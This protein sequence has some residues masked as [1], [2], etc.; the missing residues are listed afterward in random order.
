MVPTRGVARSGKAGIVRRRMTSSL[1]PTTWVSPPEWL[2]FGY[3]AIFRG[4]RG[5]SLEPVVLGARV[6]LIDEP[7][8]CS[9]FRRLP[10]NRGHRLRPSRQ[11]DNT[12]RIGMKPRWRK[13]S[14]E[15]A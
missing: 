13:G 4:G 5:P 10:R 7:V 1:Q 3:A 2:K 15:G 11:L 6:E 8:R 9:C 12:S 14:D